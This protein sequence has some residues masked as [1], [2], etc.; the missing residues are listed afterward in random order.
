MRQCE[1]QYNQ[2]YS[3]VEDHDAWSNNSNF[4]QTLTK[5]ID[6]CRPMFFGYCRIVEQQANQ[7]RKGKIV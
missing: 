2:N 6:E 1:G 4:M 7:A 3:E 5:K